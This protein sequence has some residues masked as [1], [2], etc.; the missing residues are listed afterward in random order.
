MSANPT[1]DGRP[2]LYTLPGTV[3]SGVSF[4]WY[5]ED[6]HM[7]KTVGRTACEIEAV[8]QA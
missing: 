2:S 8:R 3:G 4:S 5:L 7:T 6:E 1:T